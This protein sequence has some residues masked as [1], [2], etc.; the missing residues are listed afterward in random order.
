MP[1]PRWHSGT[2]GLCASGFF[3]I[4]AGS[5]AT[6]RTHASGSSPARFRAGLAEGCQSLASAGSPKASENPGLMVFWESD[7]GGSRAKTLCPRFPGTAFFCVSSYPGRRR[8][9][10]GQSIANDR[11]VEMRRQGRAR[12]GGDLSRAMHWREGRRHQKHAQPCMVPACG[13][14][15]G[16]ARA[17]GSLC[18]A[19]I[20]DPSRNHKP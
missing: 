9:R 20:P 18:S 7:R 19:G 13:Q 17:K 2:A 3:P 16:T 12:I 5:E 6:S 10:E 1:L 11:A 8:K 4:Q 15:R 14:R